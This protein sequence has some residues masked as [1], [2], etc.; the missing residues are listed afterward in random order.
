MLTP[1]F[2]NWL[3]TDTRLEISS[4]EEQALLDV[5]EFEKRIETL[6][7]EIDGFDDDT[8]AALV[9]SME[10]HL[11]ALLREILEFDCSAAS[12]FESVDTTGCVKQLNALGNSLYRL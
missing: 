5:A 10:Q 2:D 7:D 4:Q 11:S 1:N 6:S 9:R 12:E 8:E 3:A